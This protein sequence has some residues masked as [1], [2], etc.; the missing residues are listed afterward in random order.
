M[1]RIVLSDLRA[2]ATPKYYKE[3]LMGFKSE[4]IQKL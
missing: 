4:E 1:C 2:G 3:E